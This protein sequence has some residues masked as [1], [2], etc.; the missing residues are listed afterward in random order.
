MT[1]KTGLRALCTRALK[2]DT[3]G[4]NRRTP[5]ARI[6]GQRWRNWRTR[7]ALKADTVGVESGHPCFALKVSVFLFLGSPRP[8]SCLCLRQSK[9]PEMARRPIAMKKIR[10]VIR[11]RY[12]LNAGI[13]QIAAACNKRTYEAWGTIRS[14]SSTGDP[15]NRYCARLG[16]QQ[17]DESGLTYMR[18]RYYESGSGRFISEDSDVQGCNWYVYANNN[19]IGNVDRDGK[20]D[21]FGKYFLA[22]WEVLGFLECTAGILACGIICMTSRMVASS[23]LAFLASWFGGGQDG[24]LGPEA[25]SD[26]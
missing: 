7:L 25:L 15:K 8:G 13:R 23:G 11:M 20:K 19:L 6:S 3:V 10:E 24:L 1:V 18:A 14:S 22:V 17:D 9:E 16:H 21:K 5:L 12:S 2:A 4:A 26:V